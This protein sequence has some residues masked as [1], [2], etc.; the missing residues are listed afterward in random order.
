M[1]EAEA[2]LVGD[3]TY[4]ME[5]PFSREKGKH[6]TSTCSG[7]KQLEDRVWCLNTKSSPPAVPSSSIGGGRGEDWSSFTNEPML[8]GMRL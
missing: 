8:D 6:S 4:M 1:A 7:G 3:M 2:A 5:V